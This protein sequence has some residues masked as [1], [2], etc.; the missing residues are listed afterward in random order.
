MGMADP[1]D[2]GVSLVWNGEGLIG[3]P[4]GTGTELCTDL[5]L[6]GR[7]SFTCTLEAGS[8]STII[9][10]EVLVVHWASSGSSASKARCFASNCV[11]W[12]SVLKPGPDS[13][14][15]FAGE[16]E[17]FLADCDRLLSAAA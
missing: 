8:E 14:W 7:S 3:T 16:R 15:G 12:I 9:G 4:E 5:L 11:D 10:E 2:P 13:A 1:Q 6:S 17:G